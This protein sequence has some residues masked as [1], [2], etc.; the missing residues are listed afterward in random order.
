M[1]ISKLMIRRMMMSLSNALKVLESS[2][3]TILDMDES[4]LYKADTN[5]GQV[6]VGYALINQYFMVMH[7]NTALSHWVKDNTVDLVGR[8]LDEI[9]PELLNYE[10]VLHEFIQGTRQ[11]PL[12]IPLQHLN[13]NKQTRYYNL[14]VEPYTRTEMITLLATV[15][16]VTE[17]T[18]LKRKLQRYHRKLCSQII[19]A[20]KAEIAL[21]KAHQAIEVQ[22]QMRTSALSK[23][24]SLLAHALHVKNNLLTTT[25]KELQTVFD[26]LLSTINTLLENY[27]NRLNQQQ[28][29]VIH[30]IEEGS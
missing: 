11:M 16:D 28:K 18:L 20:K 30:S 21:Q 13:A 27:S 12:I 6:V 22:A 2:Q 23:V 3:V 8:W 19:A 29:E 5:R 24:N 1:K 25:H 15:V 14:Q 9:F 4:S 10:K 17:T 26:D 7:H